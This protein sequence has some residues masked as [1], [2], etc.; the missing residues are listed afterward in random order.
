MSG[1]LSPA[2]IISAI[3]F[4]NSDPLTTNEIRNLTHSIVDRRLWAEKLLSHVRV[5]MHAR[6]KD[7]IREL[8]QLE[9]TIRLE[10]DDTRMAKSLYNFIWDHTEKI[11]DV[12]SARYHALSE[13]DLFLCACIY[14]GIST[15]DVAEIRTIAP[16]SVNMSRY[17]LKKKFGLTAHDD[18]DV[19]IQTSLKT[20]TQ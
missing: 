16:S 13:N 19:Y 4:M 14:L 7:R 6:G 9:L 12:L 20:L 2:E 5:M 18:L 1:I 10:I 11:R 3:P 17:R 15:T 8:R